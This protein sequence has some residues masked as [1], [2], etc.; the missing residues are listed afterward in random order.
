M[1]NITK[2]NCGDS[3]FTDNNGIDILYAAF[4]HQP[5]ERIR[6]DK[7]IK[8]INE[9]KKNN[10]NPLLIEYRS[11][12]WWGKWSLLKQRSEQTGADIYWRTLF[13]KT[14]NVIQSNNKTYI[15]DKLAQRNKSNWWN[16]RKKGGVPHTHHVKLRIFWVR[17]FSL[18]KRWNN[19]KKFEEKVL[20]QETIS[21]KYEKALLNIQNNGVSNNINPELQEIIV[22]YNVYYELWR[23]NK[24]IFCT[25]RTLLA[26]CHTGIKES[27][28]CVFDLVGE[29]LK[30]RIQNIDEIRLERSIINSLPHSDKLSNLLKT[31]E[32]NDLMIKERQR[33]NTIQNIMTKES[34]EENLNIMASGDPLNL[35]SWPSTNT[36]SSSLTSISEK[37]NTSDNFV[38]KNNNY[39]KFSVSKKSWSPVTVTKIVSPDARECPQGGEKIYYRGEDGNIIPKCYNRQEWEPVDRLDSLNT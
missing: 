11:D 27:F 32:L 9:N 29:A 34:G 31:Y 25:Y 39:A 35:Q 2:F 18:F 3:G 13:E 22:K 17:W 33:I 28:N 15:N 5:E 16:Q 21:S 37:N 38:R 7:I 26:E 14:L 12:G 6:T 19:Y 1:I 10:R 24:P 4:N 36:S 23:L 20:N 30:K 8:D